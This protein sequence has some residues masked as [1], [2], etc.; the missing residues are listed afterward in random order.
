MAEE[1]LVKVTLPDGGFDS[2]QGKMKKGG[3]YE[4]PEEQ[5]IRYVRS[6]AGKPAP[7]SA[8]LTREED[9]EALLADADAAR[10]K[11]DVDA[12][13]AAA[14]SIDT[15]DIERVEREAAAAHEAAKAADE[16]LV[17][18]RRAAS[19]TPS[20]PSGPGPVTSNLPPA[21][22]DDPPKKK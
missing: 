14:W 4:F 10:K 9:R 16:R 3:T 8:K 15:R 12:E 18:A 20:G 17:I 1:K 7:A 6:G 11:A 2:D 5:A 13:M 22:D 19:T 21:T